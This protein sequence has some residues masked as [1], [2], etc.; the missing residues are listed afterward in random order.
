MHEIFQIND[1][2]MQNFWETTNELSFLEKIA[3]H[4]CFYN[5]SLQFTAS[6]I[7]LR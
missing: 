4:R 3:A 5:Q 1:E 6:S 2:W 7:S